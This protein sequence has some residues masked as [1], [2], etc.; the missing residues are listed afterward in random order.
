MF[1][2]LLLST[3]TLFQLPFS[4]TYI[5]LM[6]IGNTIEWQ[7]R[8]MWT[9]SYT[10]WP[11]TPNCGDFAHCWWVGS[12]SLRHCSEWSNRSQ[13]WGP[14][15]CYFGTR[16]GHWSSG[17]VSI[18]AQTRALIQHKLLSKEEDDNKTTPSVNHFHFKREKIKIDKRWNETLVST[19]FREHQDWLSQY[20]YVDL[21]VPFGVIRERLGSTRNIQKLDDNN[22]QELGIR[23]R[24]VEYGHIRSCEYV[25]NVENEQEDALE[26]QDYLCDIFCAN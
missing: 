6:L 21:D 13:C 26:N 9:S 7:R 11:W 20:N 17:F 5:A 1:V 3:N 25:M 2:D 18:A 14:P 19:F 10:L 4:C 8:G 24:E 22:Q 23:L 12:S 16:W 15:N